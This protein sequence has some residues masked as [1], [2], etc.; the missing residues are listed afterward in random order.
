MAIRSG[1]GACV[2]RP[3]V[4]NLAGTPVG[5]GRPRFSRKSGVAYTPAKTR[6]YETNLAYAAQQAMAGRPLLEGALMVTIVAAFEIPKSF[7]K[8]KRLDALVNQVR[9]AKRPDADNIMKCCDALNGI[10]YADDA[11]IVD[12]ML[13][14]VYADKPGF[15][16]RV[17][18]A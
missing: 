5:K 3:V 18:P 16:I 12:V 13:R 6:E 11:Q 14:K 4:I 9:P 7:S 8:Q 17:E 10:V 15:S 2:T 1:G